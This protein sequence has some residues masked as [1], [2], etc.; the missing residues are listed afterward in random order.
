MSRA[1]RWVFARHAI[2]RRPGPGARARFLSLC[3][4]HRGALAVAVALAKL[5]GTDGRLD[6]SHGLP[7]KLAACH[8][9]TVSRA[10]ARGFMLS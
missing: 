2:A 9:A 10:L 4:Q 6:P 3:R 8:E 7:A 5:L 1:S